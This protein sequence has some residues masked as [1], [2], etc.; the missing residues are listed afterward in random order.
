MEPSTELLLIANG[1]DVHVGPAKNKVY[2]PITV[3]TALGLTTT[4]DAWAKAIGAVIGIVGTIAGYS[5]LKRKKQNAERITVTVNTGTT[6]TVTSDSGKKN[7]RFQTLG[8]GTPQTLY[9]RQL[10]EPIR[11]PLQNRRNRPKREAENWR[12]QHC[13]AAF[14]F[15]RFTRSCLM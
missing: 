8:P 3:T 15:L 6:G 14:L 2:L 1:K 7:R 13:V 11:V 4:E 9:L 12:R 5:F 10:I